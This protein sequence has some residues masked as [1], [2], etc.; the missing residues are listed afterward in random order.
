[1]KGLGFMWCL[2]GYLFYL[3]IYFSFL[4][5]F[6]GLSFLS[7]FSLFQWCTWL[8]GVRMLWL[9]Y[10]VRCQRAVYA[11]YPLLHN[12]EGY[13]CQSFVTTEL[14]SLG[15]RIMTDTRCAAR[16]LIPFKTVYITH[17]WGRFPSSFA[18][19]LP[20]VC[21]YQTTPFLYIHMYVIFHFSNHCY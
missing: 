18:R 1:M 21:Q 13:I 14:V 12:G 6:L 17:P 15:L 8:A 4:L 20:R 19:Q 3:L 10:P 11:L 7:V 5:F 16:R 9:S 2:S